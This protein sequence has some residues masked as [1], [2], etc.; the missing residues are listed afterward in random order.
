M[1]ILSDLEGNLVQFGNFNVDIA[2]LKAK[3]ST[4]FN[5]E[6]ISTED[7]ELY[8]KALEFKRFKLKIENN[9]IV[10]V[11]PKDVSEEIPKKPTE[12]E[13]RFIDLEMAMAAIMGGEL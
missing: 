13:Q 6:I 7:E 2:E 5:T 9:R 12:T 4:L 10:D 3:F 11:I 8:N 1:F